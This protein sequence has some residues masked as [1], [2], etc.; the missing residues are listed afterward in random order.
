[1]HSSRICTTRF[2]GHLDRWGVSARR[3]C[4]Q[5]GGVWSGERGVCVQG[6]SARRVC[7]SRGFAR[8]CKPPDLEENT[9]P[10]RGR[11]PEDPEADNNACWD[12][13]PPPRGQTDTC[14]NITFPQ[15]LLRAVNMSCSPN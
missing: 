6:V 4:V 15:L 12:T 7:V 1:M 14:K 9:P 13:P 10:L 8:G 11:H 5:G 3:V 2:N